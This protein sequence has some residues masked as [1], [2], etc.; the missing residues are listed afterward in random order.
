MPEE[1]GTSAR[2]P[3]D[4]DRLLEEAETATGLSDWDGTEFVAEL[5]VLAEEVHASGP[6]AKGRQ[7][8]DSRVAT[9]LRNRLRIVEDRKRYPEI[10]RQEIAPPLVIVGMPRTGTTFFHALIEQ[11]PANRS[12]AEWEGWRPSPPPDAATYATD[13][14]REEARA[15]LPDDPEFRAKHIYDVDLSI[16]CG[17]AFFNYEFLTMGYDARWRLPRYRERMKGPIPRAYARH[18][19]CLQH[20]QARMP[21]RRWVL[22]SP[23]HVPH[24][25]DLFAK[26]PDA[27]AVCTQRD[28]RAVVASVT[29]LF[30]FMRSRHYDDADL[31]AV[32]KD[33][34]RGM[35]DYWAHA[36]ETA[37][38][39]RRSERREG[40]IIDLPYEEITRDPMAAVQRVY[41]HFGLPL[42]AEGE[43]RMRRWLEDYRQD[44]YREKHGEH[45]YSLEQFGLSD[46][47]VRERCSAWYDRF[48]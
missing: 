28:P 31:E 43:A 30:H 12:V 1:N 29:S 45:R 32:A 38:A 44:R 23:E 6:N 22:R 34:G 36:I 39:F 14:R 2:E 3:I 33:A 19:K 46:G 10:A 20:F 27:K 21:G 24:I 15:E 37:L 4:V 42:S 8:F 9:T 35:L 11:D 7:E 17:P 26:Y 25:A 5:A 48:G 13:P 16:E 40:Q 47:E 18:R 41:D